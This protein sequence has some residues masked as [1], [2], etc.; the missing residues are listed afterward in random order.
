MSGHEDQLELS[1]RS[2]DA[3]PVRKPILDLSQLE[4][5]DQLDSEKPGALVRQL[6]ELFVA[7]GPDVIEGLTAAVKAG[8]WHTASETAHK[9]KSTSGNLGA[10]ALSELAARIEEQAQSR[11]PRKEL[12]NELAAD[13]SALYSDTAAALTRALEER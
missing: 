6:V 5:L 9:L 1:T 2:G 4:E 7:T 10:L 11:P 13:L 12:L 8:D 3:C